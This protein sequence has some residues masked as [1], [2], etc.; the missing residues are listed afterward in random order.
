MIC[1][2]LIILIKYVIQK[3]PR[4]GFCLFAIL[5]AIFGDYMRQLLSVCRCADGGRCYVSVRANKIFLGF[6]IDCWDD[7]VV[8]CAGVSVFAALFASVA[9]AGKRW[10][11]C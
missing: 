2:I 1:N 11:V 8:L 10:G 7:F 9:M 4:G 6:A 3:S 5:I